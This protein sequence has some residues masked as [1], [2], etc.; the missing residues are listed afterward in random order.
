MSAK[1]RAKC[2]KK[3]LPSLLGQVL[4]RGFGER[5]EP[6]KPKVFRVSARESRMAK[7]RVADKWSPGS[8][9]CSLTSTDRKK[10]D[11]IKKIQSIDKTV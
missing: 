8:L 1:G 10:T 3:Q 5:S 7:P 9:K 6:G 2:P 4:L 11:G